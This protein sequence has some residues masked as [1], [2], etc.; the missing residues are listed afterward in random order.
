MTD[1][2]TLLPPIRIINERLTRNERE[3]RRLRTLLRLAI[4]VD[5]ERRAPAPDD[6]QPEAAR[7]EGVA[8]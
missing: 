2:V 1:E 4:E 7:P 3:R 5:D 6:R 8:P